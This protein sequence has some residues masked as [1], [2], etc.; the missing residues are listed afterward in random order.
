MPEETTNILFGTEMYQIRARH[1][2]NF[3]HGAYK[4]IKFASWELLWICFA[5][6]TEIHKVCVLSAPW[7]TFGSSP[8]VCKSPP[9]IVSGS[10]MADI[11]CPG[12]K[13]TKIASAALLGRI[14][15]VCAQK[16]TTNAIWEVPGGVS[17][18]RWR[19]KRSVRWRVQTYPFGSLPPSS[20][21][22]IFHDL[23]QECSQ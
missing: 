6:G 11:V 22:L 3:R 14:F 19:G 4:C 23:V 2:S 21:L 5:K 9:K 8:P 15:Q 18:V 10:F 20:Y 17:G 7:A 13:H 1:V 12:H 16:C